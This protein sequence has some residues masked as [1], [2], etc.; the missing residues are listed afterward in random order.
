[1]TD[2]KALHQAAKAQQDEFYTQL[3]D[4]ENELK[5]YKSHF[6]GKK[7][8]CNCDDPFE[9][10]FF[11]YFAMNFNALGL[12]KLTATCYRGS[13]IS[14]EQLL[15]FNDNDSQNTQVI[16]TPYCAQITE[17]RDFNGDGRQDL[18]DIKYLLQNI[19]G[20]VR[21]LQG[22]GDFRSPECLEL[23]RDADIVVTNPPHSLLREYIAQL[24]EYDKKFLILG[25]INA[26]TYKEV[27]PLIMH[28]KMWIGISIHSG[29]RKF[30]VPDNYPLEAAGCGID[31]NGRK[32]IRVK[33]V[34]WLTNMAV[35]EHQEFITMIE[36]Y[37]PDKFP[38]YDNYDAIEVS[39]VQDIPCDYDGVMG[40]PITFLDKYNPEQFE[41]LG[42]TTGREE[43]AKEAWPTKRYINAVQHNPNGT[44]ANG[45]KANTRATIAITNPSGIYYTADNSDKKLQIV[46]ARILVRKISE[47]NKAYSII[48]H[49]QE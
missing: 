40:V 23:L 9:S 8:F 20:S 35:S 30:N 1:M 34:R 39:K 46:Y 37:S 12:A 33:G 27:F 41:I 43:F 7:I 38:K 29:D 36:N 10:N 18:L 28:N 2:N 5:H 21:K 44:T 22:D 14:G 24:F 26:V 31:E 49:G 13:P 11:K 17:L 47:R 48:H 4:I 6:R 16:K 25:N 3:D 15:L 32:F 42:I 45:S 19:P